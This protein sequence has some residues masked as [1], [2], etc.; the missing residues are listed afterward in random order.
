LQIEG[1]SNEA[2]IDLQKYITLAP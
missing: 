2:F 1:N